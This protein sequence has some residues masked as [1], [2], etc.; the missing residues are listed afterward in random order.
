MPSNHINRQILLD[1][2]ASKLLQGTND[3]DVIRTTVTVTGAGG[4]GKTTAVMSLCYHPIVREHFTDGFVFI[5]LGSQASDPGMKLTQLYHLLTGEYLKTCDLI[6]AEQE[7][8]QLT[9]SYFCNLLVII[10]DVWHVEDAEPLVK[11]F[12]NC[13]IVL[14]TRMNNIEQYI[15]SK[16][17][18]M[19]GPMRQNEAISL[20]T[21]GIINSS[22]LSQEDLN[23]LDE[24][25]EDAYLWPLLLSLIK[26]QISHYL[27]LHHLPYHRAIQNV[28]AKLRHK[29]LIAFD[30]NNMEATNKNHK[31]AVKACIDMTLE[32]LTKSL[33]N[34][35][36]NLILYTGIGI[37]LQTV[38]LD[39]LWNISKQEA[40]ETVEIL[41]AYGLIQ[42]TDIKLAPNHKTQQY[43]E[44]HAVISQYIIES[45][46]SKEVNVLSP[47]QRIM[48]T[49]KL[50]AERLRCS[51]Q[52]SCGVLDPSKLSS[53]DYLEYKLS[54][55]ENDQLPFYIKMINRSIVHDPHKVMELLQRIKDAPVTSPY[56]MQLVLAIDKESKPLINECKQILNDAHKVCRKLHQSVQRNIFEG[57]YDKLIQTLEN[58]IKSYPVHNVAQNAVSLMKKL[59]PYCDNNELLLY[60]KIFYEKFQLLTFENHMNN[61][62]GLP[63]IKLYIWLHKKIS[64]ALITGSAHIKE[65][66]KYMMSGKFLEEEELVDMNHMINMQE[67]APLT[68]QMNYEQFEYR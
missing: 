24:L 54:E 56:I 1:E 13:R 59:L 4:F 60:V 23:L 62:L 36:K 25:A 17:S 63:Y 3:P 31:S 37:S 12:S 15:P 11:A 32:L 57:N 46:D 26:G 28:H 19:V 52:K 41:W 58:F 55:I 48:S 9:G 7:I 61:T 42:L 40:V 43:V 47:F 39:L 5:E 14:T 20:L 16:Q 34:K 8:Q 22:Q 35:I 44:V 6:L 68:F 21:N 45:M 49:Q 64:N 38:V 67:V 18:V 50:I 30:K 29:G 51:F 33:S 2:I 27:K 53:V 66:D 10:D 65:T